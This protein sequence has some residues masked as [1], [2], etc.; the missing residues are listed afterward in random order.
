M[1]LDCVLLMNVPRSS[2]EYLHICG[3]VG[4]L[5]RQ[6]QAIIIID[7][8][9]ELTRMQSLYNNLKINGEKLK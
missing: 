1:W 4:R 3:R 6:G 7:S 5:G 2:K 8:D 9:R